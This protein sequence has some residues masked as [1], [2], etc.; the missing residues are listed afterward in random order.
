MRQTILLTKAA[1]CNGGITLDKVPQHSVLIVDDDVSDI[2]VLNHILK[3]VYTVYFAK[4]GQ[5]ALRRAAE[6]KPDIILLDVLMPDMNGFEVLTALKN[7]EATKNIPVIIITGLSG[8]KDEE[9]GLR[10]GAVDYITK[11]FHSAIV[12]ARVSLH[13]QITERI[14]EKDQAGFVLKTRQELRNIPFRDLV[15]VDVTGHWLKFHMASGE[16]PEVYAT[17]KEY[18]EIILADPRFAHSHKSFILNMDYVDVVEVSDVVMKD[19][20]RLPISKRYSDFK[21]RYIDWL[22]G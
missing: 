5:I 10:L 15:Y 19:K 16:V 4:S 18:E 20:T 9:T 3:P 12:K 7:A 22:N 2:N 14:R 8:V 17:L 1:S 21:K 6:K 11:P 13:L